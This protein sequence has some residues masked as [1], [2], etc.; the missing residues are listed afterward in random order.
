MEQ[1]QQKKHGIARRA[2]VGLVKAWSY[3]LG[4]TSLARE[5]KRIGGNL[6][7]LGAHVRRKLSDSPAN[8]RQES[9][10]EAV[11]RLGLD[12]ARLVRQA[13]AFNMRAH[14]WFASL[15]LATCWLAYISLSDAP[16]QHFILCVGLMF[17]TFAKSITWRFRFCQ[18]R[19]QELYSFTTWLFSLGR[20]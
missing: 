6:G 1:Q 16:I 15:I 14:S 10:K 8:Y 9:F 12:E 7:A 18:I 2:G 19:D 4:I 17:M 20:W 5:G 11:Q 3:S 13:R